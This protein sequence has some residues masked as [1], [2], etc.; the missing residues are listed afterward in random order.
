MISWGIASGS[1]D[2]NKASAKAELPTTAQQLAATL[3]LADDATLND[4]NTY[5]RVDDAEFKKVMYPSGDLKTYPYPHVG[6]RVIIYGRVDNIAPNPQDP[7]AAT[8]FDAT[9]SNTDLGPVV[10]LSSKSQDVP[11]IGLKSAVG[12]IN[13]GDNLEI[14]VE[15]R[16]PFLTGKEVF[17]SQVRDPFLVAHIVNVLR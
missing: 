5:H 4:P 15:V 7:S 1:D 16:R 2:S 10:G 17:G 3:E 8:F 9:T 6:S 14:F 13:P 11:I 12:D